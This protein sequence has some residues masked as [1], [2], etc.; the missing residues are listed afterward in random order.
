MDVG[1]STQQEGP[2]S[3]TIGTTLSAQQFY[4]YDPLL[5]LLKN[6]WRLNNLWII[7]GAI[8]TPGIVFSFWWFWVEYV[9]GS[10]VQIWIPADT[11]SALLQTFVIFPLLK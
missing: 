11:V 1:L 2:E 4:Q 3:P 10:K 7:A 6:K 9:V 5:V 8:V